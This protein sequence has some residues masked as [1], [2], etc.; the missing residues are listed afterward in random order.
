MRIQLVSEANLV[1]SALVYLLKGEADFI[2]LGP[3]ECSPPCHR[4]CCTSE[5]DVLILDTI[6]G[7][8]NGVHCL[9]QII[10][11]HP[12]KKVLILI[13]KQ[14][15]SQ[16]NELLKNGAMGVISLDIDPAQFTQAVRSVAEGKPFIGPRLLEAIQDS[17]YN[18]S[19][20]PFDTLSAR[21]RDVLEL[22]LRGMNTEE[23]ACRLH[24]SKKTVANH[25][26]HIRKKLVVNDL[27]QL[28][29]LAIRHNIIKA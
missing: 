6:S 28:T 20:N 25:Y 10:S 27:V 19:T 15:Y 21:E 2:V 9:K 4:A 14:H 1:H 16:T 23:C 3:V 26:T 12:E 17:P 7:S 29:R 18:N 22:I 13:P 24:I 11:R 5:S 8:N